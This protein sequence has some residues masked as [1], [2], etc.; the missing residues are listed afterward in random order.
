MKLLEIDLS[1]LSPDQIAEVKRLSSRGDRS[2]PSVSARL[3]ALAVAGG[4]TV[5]WFIWSLALGFR[6]QCLRRTG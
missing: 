2:P 6:K 1:H 3:T 5:S 4:R